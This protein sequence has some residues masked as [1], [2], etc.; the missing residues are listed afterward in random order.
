MTKTNTKEKAESTNKVEGMFIVKVKLNNDNTA[1]IFYRTSTDKEA[2]EVY[3]T[4]KD[5]V[6]EAFKE[7]FQAC[8]QGFCGVMPRLAP[9]SDKITM[10]MVKFDYDKSGFLNSALYSI[11]YAFNEQTNAVVNIST[12]LLPIYKEGMEN[13]FTIAGI[14]EE[15]LHDVIA[16]SKA[17]INGETRTK[18]MKLVVDNSEE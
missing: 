8:V 10:N 5:Q 16:K 6:T 3:Y 13:T 1:S 4:G 15:A 12:P 11:K 18:Q 9:D 7:A 17:Y 2:K 14:H